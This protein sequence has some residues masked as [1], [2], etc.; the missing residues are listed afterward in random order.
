MW[1]VELTVMLAMIGITGVFAGYEIALATVSRARLQVLVREKRSGA[2]AALSM[3]GNMEASF[4]VVQLG[5][6]LAGTIAAATGGAEAKETLMPLLESRLGLSSW[7]ADVLA[8][9]ILV[10]PLT[11][12]TLVFGE[13]FPKVFG[14][15]NKEWVCL[16]LSP[17]MRSFAWGIWPA[18]WLLEKTV[19]IIRHWGESWWRPKLAGEADN[20]VAELQELRATAML[21]RTDRLIGH[22]E[23]GIILG[24]TSL[25]SRPVRAIVLP[26]D[27]ISMLDVNALP[28]HS[29]VA[30]HLDMHTRFP[31][32]ER[33]GDPQ[34]IIGY[35]TFK[36]IVAHMRLAPSESTLRGVL[37][38]I[39]SLPDDMPIA[40]CLDRL[41]REHTHIA[42]VRDA[43]EQ[44]VGMIT[45]E[46]ILEEFVGDIQDEYDRLPPHLLRSGNAWIVGGGTTLARL[47]ETSGIDLTNNLPPNGAA[48]LSD[49]LIGHLGREVR[50]GDVFVRDGLRVVVRK[51]RRH[52]LQEAQISRLATT[53]IP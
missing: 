39:L 11:A 9:T 51:V 26:A 28:A 40:D 18:V 43:A 22:R 17:V 12:V 42:L 24:A 23:E 29:L 47:K 44:V 53:S 31:V 33:E 15:R 16:K 13:L 30:A 7:A 41:L 14:L 27:H 38:P 46:D 35:V 48:N 49:W 8:I 25:S 20:E 19:T 5:M 36:D 2:D 21:A 4:A 34:A 37:R 32:T 52:K 3:R 50:R 1:G 6:T 45:L 10:V